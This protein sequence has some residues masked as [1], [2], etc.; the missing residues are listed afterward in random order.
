M[1]GLPVNVNEFEARAEQVLDG[2]TW[3]FIA[4]GAL[5]EQTLRRNRS[6]FEEILLRP[7]R[8]VDVRQRDTATTVLGRSI[9]FPVMIAPTGV[10]KR[11]HADGELATARAAGAAGT[12][13]SLGTGG[14][15]SIEQIAAAASGP[16]WFQLYHCGEDLTEMLLRR[17]EAAGYAA[18]CV[19]VD[20]PIQGTG[21]ERDRRNEFKPLIG[22]EL[23]NFIGEIAGL[24]LVAGDPQSSQ[25]VRPPIRPVT[26]AMIGWLR[27]LT[28]LPIVLKG[29]MTWED[30][31]LAVEH[32]IDGVI[33]SNHGGRVIDSVPATIEV[34]PEVVDAA[35][36]ALEVYLDG[37][38]RRGSDVLKALA[39]GARAVLI[40]RPFWYGLAV[41]GEEGVRKVLEI[42]RREFDE[43]MLFC[44]KTCVAEIDR[45]VVRLPG[46]PRFAAPQPAALR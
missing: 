7:R 12:L 22:V 36:G 24:G 39:L 27:S 29:I 45:S 16:L 8:L 9:S 46:E 41:A 14:T 18:I 15:C 11:A 37:G 30:A 31:K 5:D 1:A 10:H 26:W 4:G 17:A 25:W 28:S 2:A 38:V 20:V 21:K 35:G 32:G 33:V 19:T 13:M 42:L 44:G 43:A 40:G 23:A 6:S 34:L 3:E